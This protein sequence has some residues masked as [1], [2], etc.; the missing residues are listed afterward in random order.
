MAGTQSFYIFKQIR[1]ADYSFW[2]SCHHT[3]ILQ[4]F[5]VKNQQQSR[6]LLTLVWMVSLHL[7]VSFPYHLNLFISICTTNRRYAVLN[8]AGQNA[9]ELDISSKEVCG[10]VRLPNLLPPSESLPFTGNKRLKMGTTSSTFQATVITTAR[11]AYIPHPEPK[12]PFIWH[13]NRMD[14]VQ[15]SLFTS[16]L[17]HCVT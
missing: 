5:F 14:L 11:T 1:R 8:P 9:E 12:L 17:W 15:T 16:L 10:G 6:I 3:Q 2:C 13:W 7:Q 4:F